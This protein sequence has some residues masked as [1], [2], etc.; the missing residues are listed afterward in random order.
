MGLTNA[1]GRGPVGID[2]APFIYF[3]E[4][5][6]VFVRVLD[7]LFGRIDSSKLTAVT[8]GITLLEVLVLPLRASNRP[9]A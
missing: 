5:H 3:I 6:P 9:L 7:D 8:S 2:T 4:E 1:L